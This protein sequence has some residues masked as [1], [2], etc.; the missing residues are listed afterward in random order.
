MKLPRR[1]PWASIGDLDQLC[2]WI[3][4]DE[5]DLEA[6][7]RAVERLSAWKAITSL[8]HAL[9]STLALLAVILQDNLSQSSTS[10]LA[11]RQSYATALIRLVNGLVDPLQSGA[12]A[13]SIASIAAQLGLP[14]WL[15]EL[16]HAATHEDLPSL[17]LLRDAARESMAWLLHNY[18]LPTL[19]PSASTQAPAAQLPSLSP[20]LKQY[21]TLLK[22]TT[23]DTSVHEK[24]EADILSVQRSIQRWIAQAKVAAGTSAGAL[25]WEE[26]E[27]P[28]EKWAL[29]RLSDALLEKGALV[30][31]SKKKRLFSAD[32]FLPPSSSLTLWTPLLTQIYSEHPSFPYVL[33]QRIL[34]TMLSTSADV[35]G[36][37]TRPDP[38]FDMCLARWAFWAIDTWDVVFEES[39]L[40]IKRDVVVTLVN[41]L[42]PGSA[43]TTRD[44]KA[45]TALLETICGD[46]KEFQEAAKTLLSHGTAAQPHTWAQGDIDEMHQR[47]HALLSTE[48]SAPDEGD[49]LAISLV[50]QP[51]S[52]S[53][54]VAPG[55]HLLGDNRC[56]G[57]LLLGL[58][59]GI[60]EL[61]P[62]LP[63]TPVDISTMSFKRKTSS[64]TAT[65]PPGTRYSP[66]S[67]STTITSTGI[68]SLDDVLGGGLP[69]SCSSLILAPDSHSAYGELVQKY[70]IAQGLACG[71]E[72]IVV[73]D[74]GRAFVEECMW[75]PG[76]P[77]TPT[78]PIED[79]EDE[80][81]SQHDDK[82]KIAWRYEQMKKFQTT[83]STS[84]SYHPLTCA[85]VT[86]SPHMSVEGWGGPGWIQKLGWVS[87]A[88][89]TLSAFT[90]N[91]SLAAIFPTQHGLLHIHTSP[92]PHTLLPPSD[93]F[94]VLRGICDSGENNLGFKCM[95]K[96]LIFETLHLD[97]EGGVG[98][99]RT[100]PSTNAM[101]LDAAM[102]HDHES[103]HETDNVRNAEAAVIQV[104]VATEAN[105]IT[106]GSSAADTV[107]AGTPE[108][109][110]IT[111]KAKKKVVFHM[112]RVASSTIDV[113]KSGSV[114]RAI[115]GPFA[116][117]KFEL[118]AAYA[119]TD[120]T[121]E[122][123]FK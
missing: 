81:A 67:L 11:L 100:T 36:E 115:E 33:V 107:I 118:T 34:A 80:K 17:E 93:K 32:S 88:A 3:F 62:R 10:G 69:L 82:I 76:A 119:I 45:A 121:I 8:P 111:K 13:R 84:S 21:K 63:L 90:A 94:S 78:K 31:L 16:R 104:E 18:F 40:D 123:K 35:S 77:T 30:P 6:K 96:R 1:V 120:R 47:L 92:A 46:K 22:I 59:F 114:S 110:G 29:E 38:S 60:Q 15:V 28:K 19:N 102:T 99:R 58:E 73:D 50:P 23:R 54:D 64:K 89:I 53:A 116:A 79:D 26:D 65:L 51:N 112:A 122:K 57:G 97:L 106:L 20:L 109:R 43:E 75:L 68:P 44:K 66:S 39:E 103:H 5:S 12:Y 86:I 72:V 83:V 27:D 87:D 91:P 25:A 37:D 98:E 113:K 41:A 42:G 14:P 52:R 70:F 101:A 4:A 71:Q 95:R 48:K 56:T 55:W 74:Y 7:K 24:Y 9:E 61:P 85:S 105:K 2:S 108:N 117:P 49:T